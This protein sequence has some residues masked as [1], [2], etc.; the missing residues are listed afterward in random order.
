MDAYTKTSMLSDA[1]QTKV[2]NKETLKKKA[3]WSTCTIEI[4]GQELVIAFPEEE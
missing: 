1:E 2:M 3:D 4:D